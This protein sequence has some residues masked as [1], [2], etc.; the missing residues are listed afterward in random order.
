MRRAVL[1]TYRAVPKELM[2]NGLQLS[3]C[4]VWLPRISTRAEITRPYL[5][6]HMA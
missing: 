1:N 2:K 5:Q 3:V 6:N 4:L